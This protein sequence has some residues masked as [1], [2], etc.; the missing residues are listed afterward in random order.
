MVTTAEEWDKKSENLLREWKEKASGYRWLHNHA[1]MHHKSISDWLSYPSIIIASVTGVGGFAFMNPTGDGETP[2][3][4]RWFQVAFA[5][6]NVIGGILTSVNKFS[7]SSSLVEKH[8]IASIAYSKLYRAIDMELTLDPEHRQQKSVADLVRSFREHY[9]RLLDE[10]PDLPCT[11]IIAFQK[12][13]AK[14]TRAKP[15]VTNGLSPVIK[16]VKEDS[17]TSSI[18][19]VMMKWKDAVMRNRPRSMPTTLSP[20]SPGMSV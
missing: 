12:K 9:D 15:E 7:Q 2:D 20:L 1:R 11:S 3:N 19:R 16:D 4:I 6:L 17:D 18:Q 5:T 10:S 8:S 13:F 14:D